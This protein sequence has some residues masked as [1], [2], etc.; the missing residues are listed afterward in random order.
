MEISF[1]SRL[2]L[3]RLVFNLAHRTRWPYRVDAMV[4]IL[5]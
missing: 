3:R 5:T 4:T 1:E 2:R